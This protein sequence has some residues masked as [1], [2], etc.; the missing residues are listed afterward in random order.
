[1]KQKTKKAA[2]KR[3]KVT[4]GGKILRRRQMQNHLKSAK[5][6]TARGR[7]KKPAQVSSVEKKII[8][9]LLPYEG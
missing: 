5:S 6:R 8:E 7:Y 1:M 9:R 3:F 2:Y 4:S